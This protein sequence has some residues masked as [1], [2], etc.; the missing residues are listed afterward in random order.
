MIV[1][2]PCCFKNRRTL[3][4]CL[5]MG[6]NKIT[7]LRMVAANFKPSDQIDKGTALSMPHV[8]GKVWMIL[9]AIKR[10]TSKRKE[11]AKN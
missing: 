2:Y 8:A 9:G 7:S 6:H 1:V 10:F 5:S 11:L 3:A 4:L